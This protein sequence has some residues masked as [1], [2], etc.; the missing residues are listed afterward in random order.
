[1][2]YG[3]WLTVGLI[4][5]AAALGGGPA[6][7]AH[8]RPGFPKNSVE[9]VAEIVA[10]YQAGRPPYYRPE[11]GDHADYVV[12]YGAAAGLAASL[13]LY[14]RNY[15]PEVRREIILALGQVTAAAVRL[16]AMKRE[17]QDI[18]VRLARE[19]LGFL[20]HDSGL[21]NI[22]LNSIR[23]L[24]DI[25]KGRRLKSLALVAES[26]LRIIYAEIEAVAAKR[27]PFDRPKVHDEEDAFWLMSLMFDI[28]PAAAARDLGKVARGRGDWTNYAQNYLILR[29]A[30]HDHGRLW[31]MCEA[32]LLSGTMP[33]RASIR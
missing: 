20:F 32:H 9:A 33:S 26:A 7:H 21:D 19:Q 27:A 5:I 31:R 2:T 23:L 11:P 4:L 3:R 15:S 17:Q 10:D 12:T 25:L 28:D 1:M 24:Q 8:F 29:V 16:G 6:A 13:Q 22:D 18:D 14:A 30:T